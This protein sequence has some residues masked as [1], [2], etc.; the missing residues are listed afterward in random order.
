M[1]SLSEPLVK[2]MEGLIVHVAERAREDL[3]GRVDIATGVVGAAYVLPHYIKRFRDRY[4]GVRVRVRN[5]PLG[6]G[7]ALLR[8]G[9]VEFVLGAREPLEDVSFEYREM[10]RYDIVLITALD[11]PL[12]GRETVTPQEAAQWPMIAPPAGSYG[13]RVGEAAAWRLGVTATAVVEV[14]GWGV[15]KRYVE[16]G[17]G[18]SVVPSICLR[19]SDRVSVISIDD[20]FPAQSFGVYTWRNRALTAPARRL[21]KLMIAEFARERRR[22]ANPAAA[23]DALARIAAYQGIGGATEEQ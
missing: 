1:Y 10:L 11:H 19:G 4:P 22:G 9:D 13:R 2:E 17:F 14:R 16:W 6:K 7:M 21:L 12:A 15:I 23:P 3:T 18:A 5:R 20:A 8:T